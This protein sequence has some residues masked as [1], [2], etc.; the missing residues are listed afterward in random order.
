MASNEYLRQNPMKRMILILAISAVWSL[1]EAGPPY[2]SH[3]VDWLSQEHERF[4]S[5]P[6]GFWLLWW[7]IFFLWSWYS[8]RGDALEMRQQETQRLLEHLREALVQIE[9]HTA[10]ISRHTFET[11]TVPGRTNDVRCCPLG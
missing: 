11:S 2:V 9:V 8:E 7:T 4:S 3:V 6:L 10:E 1:I 5:I